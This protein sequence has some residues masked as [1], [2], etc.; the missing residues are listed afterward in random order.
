MDITTCDQLSFLLL[1]SLFLFLY[2]I[3]LKV[4]TGKNKN[5]FSCLSTERQSYEGRS[6]QS[7]PQTL[8][9]IRQF[10]CRGLHIEI[11]GL[12]TRGT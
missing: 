3:K 5:I 1:D 9:T 11:T 2:E 12:P 10:H 4:K 7:L 8:V 6:S